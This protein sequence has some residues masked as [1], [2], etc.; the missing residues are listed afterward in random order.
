MSYAAFAYFYDDLM[1]ETPYDNWIRFLQKQ[2]HTF[3]VKGND[4]LDLACGTGELTLRL[5]QAGF[6]VTGVDLSNDMLTVAQNKALAHHLSIPF[7]KQNM[8]ELSGVG[9]FDVITIFCDSLNYLQTEADVQ[10]TFTR[11]YNH[12][13]PGGLFLF[14]V[15]STY[16]MESVFKDTTFG[17]NEEDISYVWHCYEGE[18]EYSIQHELTFFV[19][20]NRTK[21]YN[22]YD[23]DHFQRTFP[24][25]TYIKWLKA[26]HFTVEQV[27]ADFLDELVH[28]TSERIFFTARR[29]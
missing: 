5:K 13:R 27:T 2:R 10:Q 7:Y 26:A 6:A 8:V 14:D 28:E 21:Q 23:E 4:V 25:N 22:R 16:K 17:L 9:Q 3:E 11:V 29:S 19:L 1:K 15:H 24:I 20:D 12:L 18:Y